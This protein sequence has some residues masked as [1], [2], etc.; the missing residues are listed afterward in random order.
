MRGKS[1]FLAIAGAV[2]ALSLGVAA[3]GDDDS[4]D[5]G[6]G[7]GG[8]VDAT[9]GVLVPQTGDLSA[10][11]PAG[12][13]AAELAGDE[14]N[15]AFEEVGADA[16]L[17]VEVADTETSDKAGTQAARQLISD[18][19]SCMA[20]AWASAVTIPVGTSVAARQ[21]VPLIS[22]ASTSPEITDLDD[23]GFVF[24]VAPSDALQGQLLADAVGE[25]FGTDATISAAARNDAYGEGIITTFADA[26]E[27]NGGTI[28]GPV[29]YDPEASTYNSEAQQI[30]DGGPDG[31]VII[32]F[33]DPYGKVGGAL[34][35]T[36]S[37]DAKKLFTADGLA[38]ADGIP[39][40]IPGDA[41]NG[42]K[43]TRP[44]TPEDSEAAEAF[45]ELYTSS[46]KD[47]KKRQTF[48]AQNFDAVMLCA[49][50]SVAAGSADGA[51]IADQVQAVASAPGTEFD[52]TDLS[53][54]I[55][56]LEN[57]DDIDFS[58]VSGSL[59]LDD[60]GDPTVGF[61]DVWNYDDSGALVVDSSTE[62]ESGE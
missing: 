29:L 4:D 52:Y 47:P 8:A 6:G 33:E 28:N 46:S 62:L 21:Q 7:D 45:N 57:G 40:T 55:E 30:V 27:E 10:F 18:G 24:R 50:A 23:D 58:G 43:G 5:G 35:R 26:F 54:A 34:A 37:F 25:E 38:F 53:G 44:A 31:F 13:K 14:V 48:D 12:Q 32:D 61:Y 41:I 1:K 22:P 3:C 51:E 60:S 19:A 56:A 11:G 36:G 42:A 2:T 49:L 20:G 16:T 9:V 17:K 15:K 59:D 39:D